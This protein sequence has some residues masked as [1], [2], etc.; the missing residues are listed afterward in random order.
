[1][2]SGLLSDFTT[3]ARRLQVKSH[4]QEPGQPQE[5]PVVS[6]AFRVHQSACN[7]SWLLPA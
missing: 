3:S 5:Q 1:M 4:T 7:H 6:A 2:T